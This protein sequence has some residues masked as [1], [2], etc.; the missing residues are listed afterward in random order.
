MPSLLL[1][2]PCQ[3]VAYDAKDQ[4]A[5][6]IGVFQGFTV[7]VVK[8]KDGAEK[9]D[10]EELLKGGIPLHWVAFAMWRK[11]PE[12]DGKQYTQFCELVRPS[13]KPSAK[14][15]LKFEMTKGFQRNTININGFPVDEE[16]DY[17]LKLLLQEADKE[18][19]FITEYP[20]SITYEIGG[21]F[22]SRR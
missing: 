6:L 15:S 9:A 12:D 1:F 7:S 2:A 10:K 4:T 19:V 13:G 16:G 8:A 18:P 21:T 14:A 22:I 3:S 11:L 5:S 17:H 20:I